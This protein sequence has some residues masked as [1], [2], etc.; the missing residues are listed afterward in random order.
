MYS[1]LLQY[2][3]ATQVPRQVSHH[4]RGRTNPI[5]RAVV[6]EPTPGC[7]ILGCP[8]PH[9]ARGWC[10]RHYQRWKTHGD[11]VAPRKRYQ[12]APRPCCTVP[13]CESP[14][15]A[16]SRCNKHYRQLRG[17][18]E[19]D[20]RAQKT[21]KTR[22]WH[23]RT[24]DRPCSRCSERPRAKNLSWCVECNRAHVR[25][26]AAKRRLEPA[27]AEK[28]RRRSREKNRRDRGRVLD[29]YGRACACC[30]EATLLFLT[31]DHVNNDG[32][33]HRRA[34]G[35]R[36]VDAW[37]IRNG[38]PEG[39]QT[40]CHNCNYGKHLNGGRCPHEGGPRGVRRR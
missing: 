22:E 20:F 13:G 8:A 25:A 28:E 10:G 12:R 7:K 4:L 17:D 11:P 39:F 16:R 21:A 40:L 32:A 23:E 6:S 9:V 14:N 29:H 30:G 33:E 35:S 37:L 31:I 26:Y 5:R 38:F 2:S 18:T 27:W 34:I 3:S 1:D 36:S 15:T 24:Q 19:P